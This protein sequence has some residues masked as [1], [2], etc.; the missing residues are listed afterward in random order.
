MSAVGSVLTLTVA[1]SGNAMI[2]LVLLVVP[3]FDPPAFNLPT[4]I[5]LAYAIPLAPC[6]GI[7]I[8]VARARIIRI[9]R[10]HPIRLTMPNFG[11]ASTLPYNHV[12]CTAVN[13][14]V[15]RVPSQWRNPA[16]GAVGP[17][18]QRRAFCD[19]SVLARRRWCWRM[20][21]AY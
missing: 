2:P 9:Y 13:Q 4:S 21:H 16:R 1:V 12:T 10:Y 7:N 18:I 19:F 14:F 17:V 8:F 3:S 20:S 11:R 15:A 6:R 5:L